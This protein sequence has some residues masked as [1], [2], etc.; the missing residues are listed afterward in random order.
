MLLRTLLAALLLSA[1]AT[2]QPKVEGPV[3][4]FV[5]P[6]GSGKSTQAAAASRLLKVPIVAVDDLISGNQAEFAKV[7]RPGITGMEP[8]SD[9]L[10]NGLFLARL[11]KGDLSHGM[12]L[13]GYPSTKDHADYVS[14]LRK[15]GVLP[16]PLAIELFIPDK[17]VL[18]RTEQAKK[19]SRASVEQRLK[20]YH[21]EMDMV[22]LYFPN[23]EIVSIDGTK[24]KKQVES[25]I[26]AFL[27]KRYK[28]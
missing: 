12:I 15:K 2:A 22:R 23:A 14:N 25:E 8:H 7:R 4:L 11:V 24:S 28:L 6:P 20:D 16:K 18:K 10:L 5:G 19:E 21:R 26:G 27:R 1:L 3:V 13:D 17:T 9:P